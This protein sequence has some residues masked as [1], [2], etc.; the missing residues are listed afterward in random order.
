[1]AA[2]SPSLQSAIPPTPELNIT[3]FSGTKDF[4]L[5]IEEYNPDGAYRCTTSNECRGKRICNADGWCS[6]EEDFCAEPHPCH[7]LEKS[8]CTRDFQCRGDRTCNSSNTCEGSSGC[9]SEKQ[10]S[11]NE[12]TSKFGPGRCQFDF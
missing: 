9:P 6:G 12:S 8:T 10:C 3:P 2:S 7:T 11:L 1:M 5:V 4:C